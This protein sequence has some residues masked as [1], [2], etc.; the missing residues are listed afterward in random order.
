[1]GIDRIVIEESLSE[2]EK[3]ALLQEKILLLDKAFKDRESDCM[4]RLRSVFIDFWQKKLGN[5]GK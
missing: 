4:K 3:E 1:M 2:Q 5:N